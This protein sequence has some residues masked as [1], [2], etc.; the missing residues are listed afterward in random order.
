MIR[1]IVAVCA[2]AALSAPAFAAGPEREVIDR[3][4]APAR[5]AQ[6]R[7]RPPQRNRKPT[8]SARATGSATAP[9]APGR[10]SN[11]PAE[12]RERMPNDTAT[13]RKNARL[14]GQEVRQ[15]ADAVP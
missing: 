6:K 7:P 10:V 12:P 9:S 5:G 4:D 14:R 15:N 2:A 11:R 1:T 8:G 3:P 13:K